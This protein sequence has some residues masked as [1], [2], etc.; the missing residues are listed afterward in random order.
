MEPNRRSS[1]PYGEDA[2]V[3]SGGDGKDYSSLQLQ[4]R[5]RSALTTPTVQDSLVPVH[6][7]ISRPASHT[8]TST[9]P[10]R[11]RSCMTVPYDLQSLLL[12]MAACHTVFAVV[13]TLQW[14]TVGTTYAAMG[15][16]VWEWLSGFVIFWAGSART[17]LAS[18]DYGRNVALG[19]IGRCIITT[20]TVMAAMAAF[21]AFAMF[22]NG[23]YSV[24]KI[25]SPEVARFILDNTE[26]SEYHSVTV[27][28]VIIGVL[29][30]ILG[31]VAVPLQ[32][33]FTLRFRAILA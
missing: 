31:T 23:V 17:T 14:A 6:P 2:A 29:N 21:L 28:L 10:A 22:W 30:I 24:A 26:E 19:K 25:L 15:F 4:P 12:R 7:A 27:W 13:S 20:F 11:S 33:Y 3:L 9:N 1:S 16:S 5:G 18:M 8:T 32:V